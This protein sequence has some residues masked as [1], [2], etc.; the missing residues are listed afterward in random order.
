LTK[1]ILIFTLCIIICG[2]IYY[3][4]PLTANYVMNEIDHVVKVTINVRFDEGKDSEAMMVSLNESEVEKFVNVL[5]STK[6][7][8]SIGDTNIKN[9]SNAYD[10]VLFFANSDNYSIDIN[11]R[12]DLVVY[13]G[14]SASKYRI[15]GSEEDA[16]FLLISDLAH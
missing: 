1:K 2:V 12:G 7:Q 11:D 16:L 13:R 6:F 10:I 5:N 4:R 3:F 15:L 9:Q 8:R 14:N